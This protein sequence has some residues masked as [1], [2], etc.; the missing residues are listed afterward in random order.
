MHWVLKK[1]KQAKI[2]L[3]PI[4]MRYPDQDENDKVREP[5]QNVDDLVRKLG[6]NVDDLVWKLG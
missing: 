5:G 2:D 3:Q 4:S 1:Y 6:Q